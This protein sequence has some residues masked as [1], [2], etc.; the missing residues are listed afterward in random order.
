LTRFIGRRRELAQACTL[1]QRED[2]RLVTLTGPGG[3]GKTRLALEVARGLV[4]A[5][6]DGVA[7]V[8]L[9][10]VQDP[11]L[12]VP[13]IAQAFGVR[14]SAGQ[15]LLENLVEQVGDRRL[16]LVLGNAPGLLEASAGAW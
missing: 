4:P 5:F 12:L 13:T 6:P 16:L 7:F 11:G 1:L 9:A 15:S 3:T 10:A 14:E 2:V 8:A